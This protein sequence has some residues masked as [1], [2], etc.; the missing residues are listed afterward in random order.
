MFTG[1]LAEAAPI[2]PDVSV[3]GSAEY[4][5]SFAVA[6]NASHSG[7][8]TV[9]V[10]GATT[11]TSYVDG[12]ASGANPLMGTLTDTGD[13]F[14]IAGNAAAP[15]SVDDSEF[16]V[17]ID[18]VMTI[19]NSSAT[20]IYEVTFGIAYINSVNSAGTDA[21]VD[22]EFTL[23]RRAAA[24]PP[25]GIEEFFTDIITDTVNGNEV[26]GNPVAGFGGPLSE[27]GTD[28]LVLT[29]NPGDSY[30]LEGDWTMKGGAYADSTSEAYLEE[31]DL[32][33]TVQDVRY[34]PEP[35]TLGLAALGLL[36]LVLCSRRRKR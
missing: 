17:G 6:D 35:S 15:P 26:G 10:G 1:A 12:I 7:T 13:G 29:L 19:T 20:D 18:L 3:S 22:S 25:P 14:G 34:I 11:T 36:G 23:D 2:D 9:T 8:M 27:T 33:L 32:Q 28:T 16:E 24:D 4:D 30:I 21:Y 5:T 31:F